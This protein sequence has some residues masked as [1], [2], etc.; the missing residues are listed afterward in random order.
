MYI[1]T[2]AAL[3]LP[4]YGQSIDGIDKCTADLHLYLSI[5]IQVNKV[6]HK[7]M[8]IGTTNLRSAIVMRL[9]VLIHF[10]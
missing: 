1:Y 2:L 3:R 4:T 8:T 7:K 6:S 10:S 9:L 5:T